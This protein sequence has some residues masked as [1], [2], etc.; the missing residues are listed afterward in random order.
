MIQYS[1]GTHIQGQVG[2]DAYSLLFDLLTGLFFLRVRRGLH[3]EFLGLGC[4]PCFMC[5]CKPLFPLGKRRLASQS[6]EIPDSMR[7]PEGVVF[8]FNRLGE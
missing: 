2:S 5:A 4:C 1:H 7:S 8:V 6:L 3:S